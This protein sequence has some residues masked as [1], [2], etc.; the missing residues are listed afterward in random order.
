MLYNY[1]FTFVAPS[2]Y[3]PQGIQ[4]AY[5]ELNL[6]IPPFLL[7]VLPF[8]GGNMNKVLINTVAD[9]EGAQQALFHFFWIDW[10]G[11]GIFLKLECLK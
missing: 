4:L 7:N 10:G 8:F 9:P 11:G 5:H 1:D 6:G 3:G 2:I